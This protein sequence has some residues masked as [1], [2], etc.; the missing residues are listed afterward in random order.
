M[1]EVVDMEVMEV[2]EVRL[3]VEVVEAMA[4]EQTVEIMVAVEADILLLEE[5]DGWA[6]VVDMVDVAI[7]QIVLGLAVEDV[8][9]VDKQVVVVFV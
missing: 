2:M 7:I 4:M 6:V 3:E 5:M 9:G 1:V 8:D